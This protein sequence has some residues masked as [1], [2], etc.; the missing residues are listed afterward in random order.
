MVKSVSEENSLQA[1]VTFYRVQTFIGCKSLVQAC[2]V[3]TTWK[4]ASATFVL[5][6]CRLEV[7][8]QLSKLAALLMKALQKVD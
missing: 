4:I 2:A 5:L 1:C 3:R 7:N 6:A 8:S